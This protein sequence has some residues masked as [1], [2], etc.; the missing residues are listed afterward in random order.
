[1]KYGLKTQAKPPHFHGILNFDTVTNHS[2]TPPVI[3]G[4]L[5]IVVCIKRWS[6]LKNKTLKTD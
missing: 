4:K 6:L 1:M 5:G 2:N 3:F